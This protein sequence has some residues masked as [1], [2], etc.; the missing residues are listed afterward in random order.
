MH[1]LLVDDDPSMRLLLRRL[2]SHHLVRDV[3][4]AGDGESALAAM[5]LRTPDALVIDVRM[6]GLD[7]PELLRAVRDGAV[8]PDVPTLVVSSVQERAV[9]E[10]L[11]RMQV[12]G[13]LLKPLDLQSAHERIGA[14]V[15]MARAQLAASAAAEARAG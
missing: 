12:M 11:C 3:A 13:Y 2:L 10:E 8:R 5:T 1:V 15:K 9:V 6:P 4:E 7:G 14:F